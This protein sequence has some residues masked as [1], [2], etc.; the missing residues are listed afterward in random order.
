MAIR[1]R[2]SGVTLR[3]DRA[4]ARA[5]D[6]FYVQALGMAKGGHEDEVVTYAFPSSEQS[7][8]VNLKYGNE[9]G[10][11][12]GAARSDLYWKI[13][14]A[15][16]DVDAGA[17]HLRAKHGIEV[18]PGS[19]FLDVGYLTH[20]RDPAHFTIELLQNRFESNFVALQ[21]HEGPL[22]QGKAYSPVIGQVTARITD[23]NE[24]L[25]FYQ[26]ALGMKLVCVEPVTPY[27]FALYFLAFT[28]EG[29]PKP[30]DLEAV[31]NREWTYS[32]PYTT[33]E[34]QHAKGGEGS[35]LHAAPEGKAG[36]ES[37][38]VELPKNRVEELFGAG[39]SEGQVRD[40][41]GL[42][43]E[44]RAASAGVEGADGHEAPSGPS[45]L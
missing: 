9:F 27:G 38:R 40:P 41:D 23:P 2:L 34:L 26:E 43:V 15:L 13:G 33:L 1:G 17:R 16:D 42:L 28:D 24:S 8:V 25:G 7:C 12:H 30:E 44:V 22:A 35:L 11:Y 3:V 20:M 29:P 4:L 37:I 31:E 14:V 5:M 10:P 19:Q 32:R 18:G 39:T 6:D 21:D 45:S 36:F